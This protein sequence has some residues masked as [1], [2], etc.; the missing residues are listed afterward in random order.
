[1]NAAA[2]GFMLGTLTVKFETESIWIAIVITVGV[3]LG[4]TIFAFQ[5]KW[6]F[7]GCA[8]YLWAFWWVVFIF[9]ITAFIFWQTDRYS[10]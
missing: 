4:L 9:G 7:T 8:M 5:T 2:E 3:T 1:M 10:H 6:D